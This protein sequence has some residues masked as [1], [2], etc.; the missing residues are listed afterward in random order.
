MFTYISDA[1]ARKLL[2]SAIDL[3]R[4]HSAAKSRIQ[5]LYVQQHFQQIY[6]QLQAYTYPINH[7]TLAVEQIP[8]KIRR[9]FVRAVILLT[10]YSQLGGKST[11]GTYKSSVVSSYKCDQLCW[12]AERNRTPHYWQGSNALKHLC[13]LFK[14]SNFFAQEIEDLLEHVDRQIKQQ[15]EIIQTLIG[16]F[17]LGETQKDTLSLFQ[18]LFGNIPLPKASINCLTTK[19][20]VVFII[21]YQQDHLSKENLWLNFSATEQHHISQFLTRISQFNFKQFANFP[22]FGY[23]ESQTI[24]PELIQHLIETTGYSKSDIVKAIASSVSIV[25]TSEAESFLL[26]D[27][28]G[29]YWQSILTQFDK[30]YTYLAQVNEALNLN[31]SVNTAQGE[32]KLQ[33][34]FKLR[35]GM[36]QVD[37]FLAKQFFESIAK[38]R[39]SSLSTHLIGE[40]LAD[41]NE[42]KWLSQNQQYSNLLLSSSCFKDYPTKLD[43]T[44]KDLAFLFSAIGN[45]L[46][47][48]A[49]SSIES[50]LINQFKIEDQTTLL[51]LKKSINKLNEIFITEYIQKYQL[52]INIGQQFGELSLSLIR[53]INILNQLYVKPMSDPLIPWQDLI[54]LFIGNYQSIENQQDIKQLN[55]D[56]A[57]YFYPCWSTL[58]SYQ[59]QQNI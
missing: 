1:E 35:R 7:T 45:S 24:N 18:A 12:Y 33:Q 16:Q 14:L 3:S 8:L 39:I 58:N 47:S 2:T 40:I 4:L 51:S 37:Q 30:D 41:I 28:W 54:I 13:Q 52:S 5:K 19:M 17:N 11:G 53:L 23:L 31:T 50:E 44:L 21:D 9:Y 32:I 20:Q 22:S 36:I 10:R 42:Y 46:T 27:I 25:P 6:H 48:L 56:L 59:Q 57:N 29:H 38:R 34:L 15:Q 49:Q 55:L 43:L 26:H